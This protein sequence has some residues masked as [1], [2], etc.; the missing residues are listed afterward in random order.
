[1]WHY[2]GTEYTTTEI[3]ALASDDS[4]RGN[5]SIKHFTHRS[6]SDI[7]KL[8]A[9]AYYYAQNKDHDKVFESTQ[10]A[11]RT[12]RAVENENDEHISNGYNATPDEGYFYQQ[13]ER[14][15]R[16]YDLQLESEEVKQ[17][18]S[19]ASLPRRYRLQQ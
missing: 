19:I 16:T 9:E 6:I 12:I 10:P 17:A 5:E 8:N 14:D 18:E 4:R 1:M 15:R 7:R 3:D 11:R 13:V 2:C